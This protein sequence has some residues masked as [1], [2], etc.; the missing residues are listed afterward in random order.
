VSP[1]C[2]GDNVPRTLINSGST[3]Q[4]N[5]TFPVDAPLGFTGITRTSTD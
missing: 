4:Y 2:H 5:F 1:Q 3:F